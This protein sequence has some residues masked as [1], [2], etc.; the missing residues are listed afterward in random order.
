[1]KIV[2]PWLARSPQRL[3]TLLIAVLIGWVYSL[4]ASASDINVN[5]AARLTDNPWTLEKEENNIRVYTRSVDGSD[6]AA[7][8]ASAVMKT[9]SDAV[10]AALGDGNGCAEWRDMCKSS[11]VLDVVSEEERLIYMV[12]D[13]PWPLSD[14]DVVMRSIT[15][16]DADAKKAT[17]SLNSDSTAHPEQKHVRAECN[18]QFVIEVLSETEVEVAYEMHADL[19]GNISAD[20]VKSRQLSATVK[21]MAALRELVEK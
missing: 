20:L 6:F 2:S 17:V 8:R 13:L 12:L 4:S 9:N 18:G 3:P 5:A 7:I 14:R 11:R 15:A 21:E 10:A 19:G 1:M 16:I